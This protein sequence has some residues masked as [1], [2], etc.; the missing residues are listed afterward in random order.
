MLSRLNFTVRD[1]SLSSDQKYSQIGDS[2]EL[3]SSSLFTHED[4]KRIR[5]I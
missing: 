1:S 5:V 3:A 4:P 2:I